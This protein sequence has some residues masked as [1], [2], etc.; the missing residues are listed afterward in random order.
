MS[1]GKSP[2]SV[3]NDIHASVNED[4]VDATLRYVSLTLDLMSDLRSTERLNA[5][6]ARQQPDSDVRPVLQRFPSP[7]QLFTTTWLLCETRPHAHT[8]TRPRPCRA[9]LTWMSIPLKSG[10]K[11]GSSPAKVHMKQVNN[12]KVNADESNR[13]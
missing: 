10:R 2:S 8:D 5:A 13:C 11:Y 3:A 6:A 4:D 1:S 7:H 12:V 9:N